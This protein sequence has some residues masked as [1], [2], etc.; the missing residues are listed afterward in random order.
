MIYTI[1][2]SKKSP[3]NFDMRA[4]KEQYQESKFLTFLASTLTDGKEMID[5]DEIIPVFESTYFHV[6]IKSYSCHL[7]TVIHFFFFK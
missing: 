2:R 1:T 7:T 4:L 3:I 5:I 6:K